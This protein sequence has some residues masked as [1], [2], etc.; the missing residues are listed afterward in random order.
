MS[1]TKMEWKTTET[2][3]KEILDRAGVDEKDYSPWFE[4]KNFLIELNEITSEVES[5]NLK[6]S[7]LGYYNS[8]LL[9]QKKFILEAASKLSN[10][11]T[12]YDKINLLINQVASDYP[13]LIDLKKH[14][15]EFIKNA[16][17]EVYAHQFE[18]NKNLYIVKQ[19]EQANL[20]AIKKLNEKLERI[21]TLPLPPES[22]DFKTL[23]FNIDAPLE[24][25]QGGFDLI[26][27]QG[28]RSS[29]YL[30]LRELDMWNA[31]KYRGK[32]FSSG[33]FYDI[34]TKLTNEYF[35]LKEFAFTLEKNCQ[36][37]PA[38]IKQ[39]LEEFA[40]LFKQNK[41]VLADLFLKKDALINELH[42]V[43][44]KHHAETFSRRAKLASLSAFAP[45]HRIPVPADEN[46]I[47]QNAFLFLHL[48]T[49]PEYA[50]S[51]GTWKMFLS[52]I[53]TDTKTETIN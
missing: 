41:I 51:I 35:E 28:F 14:C 17:E 53:T 25:I 49:N 11:I 40:N 16:I 1:F 8:D 12:L 10:T 34:H 31:G 27:D 24:S 15:V 5:I 4:F 13:A 2:N 19:R 22:A 3:P 30:Q 42:A 6:D 45:I 23:V 33:M 44:E 18:K 38:H 48:I 9:Q 43:K 50:K 39:L 36:E 20:I 29:L 46:E 37:F 47:N 7:V 52:G 21:T 32:Y 26:R